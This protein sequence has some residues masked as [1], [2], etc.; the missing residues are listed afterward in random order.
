MPKIFWLYGVYINNIYEGK[1]YDNGY[2]FIAE[3]YTA[4]IHVGNGDDR[5]TLT[6][7]C[8]PNTIK[9]YS[10]YSSQWQCN[11]S[12]GEYFYLAM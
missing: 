2:L 1:V 8:S 6:L 3:W 7:R 5:F 11:K 4:T 12:G 10:T 9:W